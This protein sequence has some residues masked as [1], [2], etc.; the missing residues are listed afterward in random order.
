M[1]AIFRGKAYGTVTV[2][3]RGQFVIPAELRRELK[4]KS[5][6]KLMV[7]AKPG[8]KV[9]NIMC[10]E[11]FTSF[12]HKAAKIISKLEKEVPKRT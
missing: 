1:N 8:R 2:G 12:L 9:I 10:E 7:F 5:G 3:G 4:I 11:D 6:D